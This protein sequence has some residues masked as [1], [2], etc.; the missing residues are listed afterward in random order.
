MPQQANRYYTPISV[1]VYVNDRMHSVEWFSDLQMA[2][3]WCMERRETIPEEEWVTPY[4]DFPS[5][6]DTMD[7]RW[8][9]APDRRSTSVCALYNRG[10]RLIEFVLSYEPEAVLR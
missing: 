4:A 10:E 5:F 2:Y 6:A 3:L 7:A 9:T 1:E 8:S